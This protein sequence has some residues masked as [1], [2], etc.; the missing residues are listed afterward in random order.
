MSTLISC[1]SS[2]SLVRL[3]NMP[4]T[5]DPNIVPFAQFAVHRVGILHHCSE[6]QHA[7][8]LAVFAYS[9]AWVKDRSPR[10]QL[11]KRGDSGHKRGCHEQ[12]AKETMTSKNLFIEDCGPYPV[13]RDGFFSTLRALRAYVSFCNHVVFRQSPC[14][15]EPHPR[16]MKKLIFRDV[17]SAHASVDVSKKQQL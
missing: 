4:K 5:R 13:M 9:H 1:G 3:R 2:L 7:K 14:L 11:D 8:Q 17:S 15:R 16:G 12:T 10:F 6:F